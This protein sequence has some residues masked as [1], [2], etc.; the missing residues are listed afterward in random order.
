[1]DYEIQKRVETYLR[2]AVFGY[3]P[4]YY[5][6]EDSIRKVS[7]SFLREWKDIITWKEYTKKCVK[8]YHGEKFYSELFGDGRK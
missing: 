5:L 2:S 4:P 1:M 3:E 8:K 6:C 7:D